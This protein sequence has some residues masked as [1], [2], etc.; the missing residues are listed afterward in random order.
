VK[1]D[2]PDIDS[3]RQ[4]LATLLD[5]LDLDTPAG[6]RTAFEAVEE[7]GSN[8]SARGLRA[9]AEALGSRAPGWS[10]DAVVA[11]IVLA[12][13]AQAPRERVAPAATQAERR[14]AAAEV[15]DIAAVL[16]GAVGGPDE[17]RLVERLRAQVE[18]LVGVTP[19]GRS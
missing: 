13:R 5:G 10:R 1:I 17:A 16:T 14:A 7:T 6:W 11:C 18:W 4:R 8:T 19:G 12:W 2:N 3:W 9:V 15:F